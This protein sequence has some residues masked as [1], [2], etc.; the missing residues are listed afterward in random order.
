MTDEQRVELDELLLRRAT[1]GLSVSDDRRLKELLGVDP[2]I[3]S[4]WIDRIV[5]ELDAL[6]VDAQPDEPLASDLVDRVLEQAKAELSPKPKLELVPKDP[7]TTA[8]QTRSRR[9]GAGT[10]MGWATAAAL[11]LTWL[12]TG[13]PGDDPT[14]PPSFTELAARDDALVRPWTAME[15][16][17]AVGATGEVVWVGSDQEGAMSFAGLQPNDP[18]EFQY[19][20]WIFDGSRDDRYPVDGG[21]FDVGPDGETVVPIRAKLNVDEPTL[22]AVTVEEPGGVVVSSRERIVLVAQVGEE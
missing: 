14:T 3:D 18:T 21:V 12:G 6:W 2:T 13:G 10:W 9:V 5:G 8:P 1:E 17:A 22:F 20:L 15:D 11:A 16:P 7:T 19:Q 4:E